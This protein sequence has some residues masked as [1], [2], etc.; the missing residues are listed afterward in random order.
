[1]SHQGSETRQRAADI[2]AMFAHTA[3][4]FLLALAIGGFSAASAFADECPG[5]RIAGAEFNNVW[6]VRID[7]AAG[8]VDQTSKDGR[9]LTADIDVAC[10]GSKVTMRE[11]NKSDGNDCTYIL[12]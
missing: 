6:R 9:H 3:R 11:L 2:G 4:P 8:T 10:V 7:I 12:N 1:M 5:S